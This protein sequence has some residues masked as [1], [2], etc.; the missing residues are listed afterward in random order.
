MVSGRFRARPGLSQ[1]NTTLACES[2]SHTVTF[3]DQLNS[4]CETTNMKRVRPKNILCD[5]CLSPSQP[6]TNQLATASQPESRRSERTGHWNNAARLYG[7]PFTMW[8]G[9]ETR[10]RRTTPPSYSI[11]AQKEFFLSRYPCLIKRHKR[12]SQISRF[13]F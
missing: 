13:A 2:E 6:T 10:R 1:K 11:V 5:V 8:R 4:L 12:I 3:A 7:L 9:E